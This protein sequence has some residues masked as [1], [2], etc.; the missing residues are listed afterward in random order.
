MKRVI[1]VSRVLAYVSIFFIVFGCTP[2]AS[3]QTTYSVA[4]VML[5]TRDQPAQ[6]QDLAKIRQLK[7]DFSE[8]FASA[9][10]HKVT[11]DIRSPVTELN[12]NRDLYQDPLQATKAFYQNKQDAFDFI[13]FFSMENMGR[14]MIVV[15]NNIEGIGL[16]LIDNTSTFGSKGMLK[17]IIMAGNLYQE[18]EHK[19]KELLH[20]LGHRW[21][22]YVG[23]SIDEGE[24]GILDASHTHWFEGLEAPAEEP[25]GAQVI[26]NNNDGTFMYRS[27]CDS[28]QSLHVR[29]HPF[30]LYFMGL[31]QPQDLKETYNVWYSTATSPDTYTTD[32][33]NTSMKG[34]IYFNVNVYDLI[35]KAGDRK[36]ISDEDL[37]QYV[38]DHGSQYWV[39]ND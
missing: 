30:V 17:A 13:I 38:R 27:S 15:K 8:A 36:E 20:L 21:C 2:Q 33:C 4:F 19:Q 25:L 5:T 35:K 32:R 29:Y 28:Q 22:C 34:E 24:L 23:N 3:P 31:S 39:I 14:S 26:V 37:Q 6:P 10:D 1:S 12:A 11:L 18:K 9:T 7:E 16:P